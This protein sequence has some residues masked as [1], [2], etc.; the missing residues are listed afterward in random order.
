MTIFLLTSFLEVGT[1]I[2]RC[3]DCLSN[4]STFVPN[5]RS[6]CHYC[7]LPIMRCAFGAHLDVGLTERRTPCRFVGNLT[8]P[9]L[10][11]GE[12][13]CLDKTHSLKSDSSAQFIPI[14]FLRSPCFTGP[15]C[16]KVN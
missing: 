4:I 13:G 7:V 9:F 1:A 3:R 16:L 15:R 14:Y 2:E 5:D 6:Q 11:A 8:F 10:I 12:D